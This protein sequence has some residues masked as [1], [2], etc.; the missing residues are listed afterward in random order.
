MS[1]Q[2]HHL[3][4]FLMF[5]FYFGFVFKYAQQLG[6]DVYLCYKK[7]MNKP[8]HY[9]AYRPGKFL[10]KLL[11]VWPY[12]IFEFL[13]KWKIYAQVSWPVFP[14]RTFPTIRCQ[15]RSLYF[16]CQWARRWRG[17]PSTP[18]LLNPCFPLLSSPFLPL[19]RKYKPVYRN[20]FQHRITY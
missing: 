19:Q 11:F 2:A 10:V 18:P 9:M 16:A 4:I 17:G 7:S 15:I 8:P 12:L 13:S 6:S 5:N 14:K 1:T 20:Q 3:I